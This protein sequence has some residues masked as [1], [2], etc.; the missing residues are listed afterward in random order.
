M[1]LINAKITNYI[2]IFCIY[3]LIYIYTI[4][5]IYYIYICREGISSLKLL[6]CGAC[7]HF[8]CIGQWFKKGG[9]TCPHCRFDIISMENKRDRDSNSN[10]S[11]NNSM[12]F[13]SSGLTITN[14]DTDTVSVPSADVG[15][16]EGGNLGQLAVYSYRHGRR[17]VP[18]LRSPPGHSHG[19]SHSHG[20]GASRPR[21]GR[22]IR[23]SSN[24]NRISSNIRI[25]SIS[26]MG[27]GRTYV[28]RTPRSTTTANTNT[29]TNTT[30]S[31]TTTSIH[32]P[33]IITTTATAITNYS[34]HRVPGMIES[35][36]NSPPP[37]PMLVPVPVPIPLQQSHETSESFTAISMSVYDFESIIEESRDRDSDRVGDGDP[38]PDIFSWTTPTGTGTSD[39]EPLLAD[40]MDGMRY[41]M[42]YSAITALTLYIA[43]QLVIL[44][45]IGL[46]FGNLFEVGK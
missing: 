32:P 23:S 18:L 10:S 33:T 3:T 21:V 29:N 27:I 1:I 30:H 25:S 26:S 16:N 8:C 6:C 28:Q 41:E 34:T 43:C 44:I 20:H 22:R 38:D 7:V 31:T 2:H 11:S 4:Y 14:T 46:V 24:W 42:N 12:S 17:L 45:T 9:K 40:G 36:L 35:H 19:H 15:V 37:P 13:N 39:L 5:Y